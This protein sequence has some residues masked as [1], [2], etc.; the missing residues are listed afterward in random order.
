LRNRGAQPV[1]FPVACDQRT[2]RHYW[3]LISCDKQPL[4]DRL[5]PEKTRFINKSL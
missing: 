1:H 3:N 5:H 4:A 2:A